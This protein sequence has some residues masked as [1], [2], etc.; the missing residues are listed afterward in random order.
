MAVGRPP[1]LL[2][3]LAGDAAFLPCGP[4]HRAVFTGGQLIPRAKRERKRERQREE[5]RK[6]TGNRKRQDKVGEREKRNRS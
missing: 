6:E 2:W 4:L 1:N 5:G 3:V